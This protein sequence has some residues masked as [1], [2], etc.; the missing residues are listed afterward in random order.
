MDNQDWNNIKWDN[1]DKTKQTNKNYGLITKGK[2]GKTVTVKK[3]F[4][5]VQSR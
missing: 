3:K 5:S 2:K 4:I 1:R